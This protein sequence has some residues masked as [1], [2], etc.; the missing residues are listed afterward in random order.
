M[1]FVTAGW[2]SWVPW[3]FFKRTGTECFTDLR[4]PAPALLPW[5]IILIEKKNHFE[6]KNFKTLQFTLI[7]LLPSQLYQLRATR[8]VLVITV[9][10]IDN[11][12]HAW[13]TFLRRDE[14][15]THDYL[16]FR[17]TVVIC[18]ATVKGRVKYRW[19]TMSI[20]CCV[21]TSNIGGHFCCHCW[22]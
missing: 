19:Y 15:F 18:V 4:I 2:L 14:L 7:V 9:L 11:R 22:N 3:N 12:S 13:L 20:A 5:I 16:S 6:N 1:P 8:F 21:Q 10:K 17:V